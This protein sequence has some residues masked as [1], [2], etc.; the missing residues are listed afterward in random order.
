[1]QKGLKRLKKLVAQD[2]AIEGV[3]IIAYEMNQG[4][5]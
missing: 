5:M 4:E 1:M 3:T 2:E